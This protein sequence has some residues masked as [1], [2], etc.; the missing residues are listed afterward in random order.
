MGRVLKWLGIVLGVL[1]LLIVGALAMLE[2]SWARDFVARRASAALGREVRIDENFDIDW[3]LT[4][5]IR[6]G[7]IH[8]ANTDWAGGGD[9]ADIG[10]VEVTL[11]LRRL[12]SGTVAIPQLT[13]IDPKLKLARD[14]RALGTGTSPT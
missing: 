12:I 11:D 13:L 8:L 1:V 14:A 7:G 5:K 2:T 6:A 9:M 10:A 4:P 3:S